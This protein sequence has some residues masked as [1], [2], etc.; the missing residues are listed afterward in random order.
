MYKG[1]YIMFKKFVVVVLAC[2]LVL[3]LFSFSANAS[4]AMH[5]KPVYFSKGEVKNA[6]IPFKGHNTTAVVAGD[7]LKLGFTG[8]ADPG[9][10]IKM[11]EN[12][13]TNTYKVLAFK[14]MKTYD[15][16][17]KGEIYY[18]EKGLAAVGGKSVKFDY[19]ESTDWQWIFIN[20][21]GKGNVGYLRFDVFEDAPSTDTLAYVAGFGFFKT[22]ADAEAYANSEYGEN[23][24]KRID[25]VGSPVEAWFSKTGDFHVGTWINQ[26]PEGEPG[27]FW[28]KFNANSSFMGI[29]IFLF[30]HDTEESYATWKLFKYDKNIEKTLQSEPAATGDLSCVGN[31]W[32]FIRFNKQEKGQYLFYL[33]YTGGEYLV[34]GNHEEP[35]GE[36]LIEYGTNAN[37]SAADKRYMTGSILFEE[38]ESGIYY[39]PIVADEP[40]TIPSTGDVSLI[41]YAAMAFISVLIKKK[42]Y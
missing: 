32:Y 5:D 18:N 13:D 26:H 39:V 23:L 12:V 16:T 36:G 25:D 14:V 7:V 17:I 29:N 37:Y 42:K 8:V 11:V 31:N 24:G 19:T 10:E 6:E 4:D 33:E 28:T 1:G 3:S 27:Y 20:M 9:I 38:N 2:V 22:Q 30:G 40:E 35:V 15:Q 21:E 41:G 34:V